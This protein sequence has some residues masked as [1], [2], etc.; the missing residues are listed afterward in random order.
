MTSCRVSAVIARREEFVVEAGSADAA[1][2]LLLRQ[3]RKVEDGSDM[4]VVAI[5]EAEAGAALAEGA[6]RVPGAEEIAAAA[7]GVLR[8]AGASLLLK[9]LPPEQE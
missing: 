8:D 3:W 9:H 2:R 4:T 7:R 5:E 1:R 6:H